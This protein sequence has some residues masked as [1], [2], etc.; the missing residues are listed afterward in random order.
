MTTEYK[1]W[2]DEEIKKTKE[3]FIV[4]SVGKLNPKTH[5]MNSIEDTMNKNVME[6]M[7]TMINTV[8]F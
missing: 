8:V 7:G 5:L 4:S 2:I 3:E 6:C 1:K